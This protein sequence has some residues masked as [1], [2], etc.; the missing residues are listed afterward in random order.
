MPYN[1]QWVEL[2]RTR[3]WGSRRSW[4][5]RSWPYGSQSAK[6]WTGRLGRNLRQGR[7]ALASY[8]RYLLRTERINSRD[9]ERSDGCCAQAWHNHQLRPELSRLALEVDRRKGAGDRGK[10]RAGFLCGR[11]DR[12][13]RRLYRRAGI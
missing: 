11:H 6:A 10:P 13:R 5:F 7:F 3:L 2:Y 8:W 1:P 12:Q 9:R 4:L